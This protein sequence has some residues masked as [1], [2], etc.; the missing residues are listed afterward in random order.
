MYPENKQLL[1]RGTHSFKPIPAILSTPKRRKMTKKFIFSATRR[2]NESICKRISKRIAIWQT[3]FS[4]SES[5]TGLLMYAR[6]DIV[7]ADG[8]LAY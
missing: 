3:A 8:H 1:L 4:F 6:I 7:A 2:A 5:R